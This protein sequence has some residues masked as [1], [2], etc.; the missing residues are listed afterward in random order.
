MLKN[1]KSATMWAVISWVLV[2]VVISVIMFMP[3]LIGK[4]MAQKAL[5]L[6]AIPIIVFFAAHM[7]LKEEKSK[8]SDGIILGIYFIIVATALDLL[9]TIPL[10]V[11]SYDFFSQWNLW[12]GY[13]ETI[14]FAA[15]AAYDLENKK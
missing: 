8:S 5:E 1:W 12:A 15:L 11:K 10:F 4:D 14:A 9:I 2:F 13:I 3:A 7:A 6:I